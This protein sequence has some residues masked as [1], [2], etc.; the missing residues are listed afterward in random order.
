MA[1]CIHCGSS[2]ALHRKIK[3][4]DADICLKCFRN[5]GFDKGYDLIADLYE[6]DQIKE[7]VDVYYAKERIKDEAIASVSVTLQTYGHE[8]DLICTEEERAVY[9]NIKRILT[10]VNVDVSPL[11]L[12]RVSDNYVTA[13]YGEWDLARIKYTNRAKWILFPVI[14]MQK[15]KHAIEDPDDVLRF[16]QIIIDSVSHIVKYS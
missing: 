12:V 5:L 7:G 13:K 10:S 2:F 16:Q 11:Q 8:R 6:Y 14:E 3:L 15:D 1:K 4:K 9:N